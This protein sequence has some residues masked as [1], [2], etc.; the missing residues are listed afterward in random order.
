M[1]FVRQAMLGK[2]YYAIGVILGFSGGNEL[3]VLPNLQ[4]PF[5]NLISLQ[6]GFDVDH[7]LIG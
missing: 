5:N 7:A 6:A 2:T 4:N 1:D 3:S